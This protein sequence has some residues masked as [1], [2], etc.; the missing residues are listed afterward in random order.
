[1]PGRFL[2]MF[3]KA[4]AGKIILSN[5]Q[6][7]TGLLRTTGPGYFYCNKGLLFEASFTIDVPKLNLGTRLKVSGIS[8]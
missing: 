3:V 8:A 5:V 4:F 6:H 2:E 1:M 7:S